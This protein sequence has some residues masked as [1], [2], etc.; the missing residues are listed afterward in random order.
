MTDEGTI[1]TESRTGTASWG[2]TEFV[3]GSHVG[4]VAR[5]TV[6]LIEAGHASTRDRLWRLVAADAP[7]DDLLD[8]LSTT[9]LKDLPSFAVAQLD[10][11]DV[12][13]VARGSARITVTFIDGSIRT[14]DPSDVRTWREDVFVDVS[15][16]AVTFDAAGD[17]PDSANAANG[18]RFFVLAGSV[19]AASLAR[20]FDRPDALAAQA[21]ELWRPKASP[22]SSDDLFDDEVLVE[23]ETEPDLVP[24]VD[25]IDDQP[26]AWPS[27]GPVDEAAPP[28]MSSSD[29]ST[30]PPEDS[31]ETIS[32]IDFDAPGPT[33]TAANTAPR[34][35]V[36]DSPGAD[37]GATEA[38]GNYDFI[39]GHTVARSV[40]GAAV[41]PDETAAGTGGLISSVPSVGSAPPLGPSDVAQV[42]QALAGDHDGMTISRADLMAMKSA[43]TGA[44]TSPTPGSNEV[45]AVLCPS[46]HPNPPHAASCRL[47]GVTIGTSAPVSVP[48]PPLG[49]LVFSNGER[50][51]ADRTVL[52]GRNPRVSG[53]LTGELPRIVKLE[54]AGQGLSRT[55]AEVRIEGWQMLLEDL[56][57]TNGTEV[58][59]PG[60]ATRRLHAGDPVALVPG[61]TV[62]FGDELQCTVE[63]VS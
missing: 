3:P 35:E 48:R 57:S 58:T 36:I 41:R 32:S 62:D 14:V 10:G 5:F 42:P 61:A 30:A 8:E 2:E 43:P 23:A 40:E 20:R 25:S 28:A 51:V 6:A 29:D 19:P 39:Y 18:D 38:D 50:V 55:H 13:L 44:S 59:L 37:G 1:A 17:A 12:R 60:Q 63:V 24:V 47:C 9:G 31:N 34:S 45:L 56:Q 11:D 22:D 54:S 16:L 52:I 26:T 15:M 33:A 4:L 7:L 46:G 21:A 27:A 53:T 49:V